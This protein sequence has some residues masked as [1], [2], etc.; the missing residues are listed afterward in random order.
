MSHG[1]SECGLGRDE[2]GDL[3]EA[4]RRI[5]GSCPSS[6]GEVIANIVWRLERPWIT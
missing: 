2:S 6:Q 5:L 1:E 3:E 4:V